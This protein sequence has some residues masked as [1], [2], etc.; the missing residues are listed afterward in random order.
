LTFQNGDERKESKFCSWEITKTIDRKSDLRKATLAV[1]GP[2]RLSS[3]FYFF[4]LPLL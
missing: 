2:E 3:L 1:L 4:L